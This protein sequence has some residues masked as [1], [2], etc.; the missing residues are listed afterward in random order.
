MD[1]SYYNKEILPGEKNANFN[2]V[3]KKLY[4]QDLKENETIEIIIYNK[5]FNNLDLNKN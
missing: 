5:F 1:D 3:L 4:D 2:I